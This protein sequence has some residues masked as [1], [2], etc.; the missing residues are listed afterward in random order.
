MNSR[1]SNSPSGSSPAGLVA[2]AYLAIRIGGGRLVAPATYQLTARFTNA[3]GLK[4]GSSVRIAGVT[5]GD[6][7]M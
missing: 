3:S 1:K 2:M 6:V 5:I 4:V 7:T